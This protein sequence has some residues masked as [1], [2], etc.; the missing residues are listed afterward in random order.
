MAYPHVIYGSYG[1]EKVTSTSRIGNVP[2]GTKMVLPDGR[3]FRQGRL[4]AA[5]AIAGYLYQQGAQVNAIFN[6]TAAAA[7]NIA[8]GT[9]VVNLTLSGT[10][11]VA[12]EFR[13]GYLFTASSTGNGIGYNYKVKANEAEADT[14]ATFNVTLEENDAIKIVTSSG[15]TKF[16]LRR[17]EYDLALLTTANTV[18][19]GP[20]AGVACCTAA[21][22]TFVWLQTKGPAAVF[23]DGTVV[24]G[25]A[26]MASTAIAGAVAPLTIAGTVGRLA[27]PILGEVMSVAASV[28]FSLVKL[29]LPS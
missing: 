5:A 10:V 9:T 8:A 21:A 25:L 26:V 22:S 3:E 13:D 17:N 4:G 11:V 1:D 28:G 23:T 29:N 27:G 16:G 15:T 2:L 24:V 12:D 14:T 7:A 18:A 19:T 6:G 20:L